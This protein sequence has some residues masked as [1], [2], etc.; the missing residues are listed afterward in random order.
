MRKETIARDVKAGKGAILGR[1][2]VWENGAILKI[3]EKGS[4]EGRY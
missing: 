1:G 4:K 2:G 3:E